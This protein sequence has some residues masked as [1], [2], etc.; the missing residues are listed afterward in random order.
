MDLHL[1]QSITSRTVH[2]LAELGVPVSAGVPPFESGD[3]WI[4]LV[5]SLY[6]ACSSVQVLLVLNAVKIT[7]NNQIDCACPVD[8]WVLVI[9]L[10]LLQNWSPEF[11]HSCRTFCTVTV[12]GRE[13]A[14]LPKHRC[15]I[16]CTHTNIKPAQ[17]K[18]MAFIYGSGRILSAPEM[19][20]DGDL[21]TPSA[22]RLDVGWHQQNSWNQVLWNI[23]HLPH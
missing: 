17:R 9:F 6:P 21:L 3:F 10:C 14:N 20:V 23:C 7:T 11:L 1:L 4:R 19:V 22:P 16:S 18:L 13:Q 12:N 8:V 5:C 2:I 15:L